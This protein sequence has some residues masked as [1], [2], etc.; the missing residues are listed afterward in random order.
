[1]LLG[2]DATFLLLTLL[3]FALMAA[4]VP[5]FI[6]IGVSAASGLWMMFGLHQAMVDRRR[7]KHGAYCW[8]RFTTE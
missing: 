1:M 4:G 7:R 5:I 3:M 2:A 6:A 8:Y